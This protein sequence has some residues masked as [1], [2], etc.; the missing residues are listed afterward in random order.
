MYGSP[1]DREFVTSSAL[2]GIVDA[3]LL[4]SPAGGRFKIS[5]EGIFL[6]RGPEHLFVF[7]VVDQSEE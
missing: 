5:E 2:E 7:E 3:V 6:M 1:A 4:A